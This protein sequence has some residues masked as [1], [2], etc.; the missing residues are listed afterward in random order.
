M[1]IADIGCQVYIRVSPGL[2]D[3]NRR[4]CFRGGNCIL[5]VACPGCFAI[6]V[7]FGL[8]SVTWQEQIERRAHV[9]ILLSP[10][11]EEFSQARR[12]SLLSNRTPAEGCDPG[13]CRLPVSKYGLSFPSR[14]GRQVHSGRVHACSATCITVKVISHRAYLSH[15][16]GLTRRKSP[17]WSILE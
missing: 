7:F 14:E 4:P 17:S 10:G 13:A 3:N 5:R 12:E 2:I 16:R 6:P 1:R 15:T 8:S 11:F 9:A